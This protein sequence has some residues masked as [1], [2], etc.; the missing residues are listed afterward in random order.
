MELNDK[1]IL[2]I[3]EARSGIAALKLLHTLGARDLTLTERKEFKEIELLAQL[4]VKCVPQSEDIFKEDWDL[5]IKNPG[6]P[7]V[8]PF[9]VDMRARGIEVI[10]EIELAWRYMKP[11]HIFAI[12]GTNGKTTTTTLAYEFLKKTYGNKA[13]V[14]GNIGTPLCEI[15]LEEDLLHNEGHYI[16][17]EISNAQL[18]DIVD[19]RAEVSAIMNLTPDHID[20]MGSLE[21]YYLSKTRV[22]EN[23]QA[24][25]V[26]IRNIDDPVL[27]DYLQKRPLPCKS[28]SISL[29]REA[30]AWFDGERLL[31]DGEELVKLEEVKLPGKHNLQNILVA[32]AGTSV[33]GVPRED[34]QAVI[35]AFEGVEHRIEFVREIDG[36]RYY[37]DSKGTNTDATITALKSFDHGVILLVGGFEKGLS[38]DEMKKYLGPVKI[39]IGY[40][41]SGKR[42]ATDLVGDAASVVTDLPEAVALAKECAA[43]GDTVLLSPT[44]SSFDQYSSFEER[45]RH[46]KAIVNGL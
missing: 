26:F 3:G 34:L 41:A 28:R 31:M 44:T 5:V 23:S 2:V 39:V 21:N 4:G 14:G 1:K 32:A 37:N 45:G 40:G 30:D 27:E 16:S 7:P 8:S 33:L 38:M 24:G 36:V 17:L 46:F 35:R 29:L 25:D 13:H 12:T 6:V 11:Q 10:T 15:V 19:F 43:P 18:A 20:F 42:I 22:Y 9:I